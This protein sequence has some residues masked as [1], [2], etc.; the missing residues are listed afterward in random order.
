MNN[1]ENYT[2]EELVKIIQQQEQE[3]ESKKYGLVWDK[4]REPEEVVLDCASNLPILKE[5]SSNHICTDESEDNILIEGDNYHA[6]S[7]L[8]YTH[9]NKI[10]VVYIDPPI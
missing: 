3:L 6:L 7:V 2:K 5:V 8:N 1:F 9:K 10:D 4:E